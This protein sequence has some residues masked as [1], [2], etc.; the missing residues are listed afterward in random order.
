MQLTVQVAV[1][2]VADQ[3]DTETLG[4]I[5]LGETKLVKIY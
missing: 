3:G 4:V 2:V 1:L 5:R